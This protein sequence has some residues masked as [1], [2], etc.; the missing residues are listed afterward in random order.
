[1]RLVQYIAEL[2]LN[3]FQ[4]LYTDIIIFLNFHYIEL[5]Y[6]RGN[7]TKF[8]SLVRELD[9]AGTLN[10][11]KVSVECGE[12]KACTRLYT[13]EHVHTYSL[14]RLFQYICHSQDMI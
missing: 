6:E 11:T 1:M 3:I 8:T 14:W 2:L 13:F 12:N 4:I 5:F 7:A 9:S 10:V